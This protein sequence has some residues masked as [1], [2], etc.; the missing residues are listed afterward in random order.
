M[1]NRRG[2]RDGNSFARICERFDGRECPGVVA[3]RYV[4]RLVGARVIKANQLRFWNVGQMFYVVLAEVT[5]AD[6]ADLHGSFTP[7]RVIFSASAQLMSFS[8]SSISV[9]SASIA[10]TPPPAS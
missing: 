8:L 3:A 5:N 2:H 7:T 6:D 10:S 9:R 1:M 4:G